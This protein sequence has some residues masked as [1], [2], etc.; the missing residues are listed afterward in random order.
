MRKCRIYIFFAILSCQALCFGSE[1]D[2]N[3]V[4]NRYPGPIYQDVFVHNQLII[5]GLNLCDERYNLIKPVFDLFQTSFSVLDIGAAQGYF[6]FRI[7]FDYPHAHCTMID[8]NSSD[9]RYH[10]DLLYDLCRLNQLD[11]VTYLRKR[12]SYNDLCF[13]SRREHFDVVL[14]FLVVHQ[15]AEK[16]ADQQMF[17]ERLFSLGDHVLVEV[18]DDAAV[19]LTHFIASLCEYSDC[20]YLGEV[21]RFQD[22][23]MRGRGALYWF[24][25]PKTTSQQRI[26]KEAFRTLNGVYP[27]ALLD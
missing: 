14:A 3:Y 22:P 12:M 23:N 13:L 9:Y 26:S 17:F 21:P 5:K 2:I 27:S 7:A 19:D 11:N 16:L 25:G 10:G 6:S 4:L 15:M 20:E 18:A 24:K 8:E 1:D